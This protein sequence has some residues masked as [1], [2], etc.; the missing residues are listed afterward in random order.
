MFSYS[1]KLRA[2]ACALLATLMCC[3]RTAES[4]GYIV[5]ASNSLPSAKARADVVCDGKN[6][7][8]LL[9]DSFRKGP[10]I[11]TIYDGVPE[12]LGSTQAFAGQSIE[13]L[14]GDYFLSSTLVI[15]QSID[16]VLHA[17]GTRL[18]YRG[19]S[20]ALL[21]AIQGLI[22]FLADWLLQAMQWL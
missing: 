6:D 15:S 2:F 14:P 11:N 21:A 7:G 13:W 8:Q 9:Y 5:A 12:A 4:A 22:R 1:L 20:G 10:W 18:F 17:H 16:T 3:M 19:A